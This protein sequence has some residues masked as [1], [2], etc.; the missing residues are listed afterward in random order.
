MRAGNERVLGERDAAAAVAADVARRRAGF[1]HARRAA[2]GDG[3][4]GR[5]DLVTFA[6]HAVVVLVGALRWTRR[7]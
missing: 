5:G 7:V 2:R 3:A 6:R 4:A 1:D